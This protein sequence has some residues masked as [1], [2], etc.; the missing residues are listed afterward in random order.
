MSFDR[1]L[2]LG[3]DGAHFLIYNP[4]TLAHTKD[5]PTGW[6]GEPEAW[7]S[8]SAA[9]RLVA[10]CTR[11]DG[12]YALRLTTGDLTADEQPLAGASW[13][14]PLHS[15]GRVLVDGDYQLPGGSAPSLA[16]D[17][18]L[19]IDLAKGDWHVTVTAIEWTASDL[20]EAEASEK[21]ANYV[22]AFAPAGD[23][24]APKMARRPPDLICLRS[25]PADD[26]PPET[27][28]Y[29][30]R[31]FPLFKKK[32]VDFSKPMA[33]GQ[34]AAVLPSGGHFTSKGE[35]D[36]AMAI[37]PDAD[38]WDAFK[39]PY[40][41][42]ATLE[43]GAIGQVCRLDGSGGSPKEPQSYR[44]HALAPARL[45]QIVGRLHDG[46][47]IPLK[48][49]WIF[50]KTPPPLGDHS[51]PLLLAKV[52]L[53]EPDNTLPT[54]IDVADFRAAVL[55]SLKDGALREVLAGEASYHALILAKVDN[56]RQLV[57][58][59]LRHLPMET[60]ARMTLSA[61]DLKT[62]AHALMAQLG[63]P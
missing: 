7:Q 61:S 44:L 10:W 3:T 8:E 46:Q 9:G 18:P 60:T 50:G 57:S 19:W 36:L 49:T 20:P 35:S 37:S 59:A 43:V 42:A 26:S 29:A 17:S 40:F 41:M 13:T 52:E 39:R 33:A 1:K 38:I 2:G 22:V 58:F 31:P 21:F 62:R 48:K 16:E 5:W 30:E 12:G 53:I 6:Y 63:R 4:E 27:F 23:R 25:E 45:T 55:R 32:P 51:H 11:S 34:C 47:S 28:E 54:D 15:P 56:P 24:P 14:F